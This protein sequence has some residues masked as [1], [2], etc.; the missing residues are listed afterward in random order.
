MGKGIWVDGIL[1]EEEMNKLQSILR[2]AVL[3]ARKG[4][5]TSYKDEKLVFEA[6]LCPRGTILVSYGWNYPPKELWVKEDRDI[7][8]CLKCLPYGPKKE[9]AREVWCTK[10]GYNFPKCPYGV[11]TKVTL[12]GG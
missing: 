8:E 2:E 1:S 3:R 12:V 5:P 7:E 4:L 10:L 6:T 11:P 9:P